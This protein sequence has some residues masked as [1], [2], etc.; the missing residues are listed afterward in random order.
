MT[1]KRL[2][3]IFVLI[4]ITAI[5]TF[6]TLMPYNTHYDGPTHPVPS[7]IEE[8]IQSGNYHWTE[9][10]EQYENVI[11]SDGTWFACGSPQSYTP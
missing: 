4:A 1:K 8:A 11:Y 3:I 5:S 9:Y 6:A 10:P 7:V 2:Y